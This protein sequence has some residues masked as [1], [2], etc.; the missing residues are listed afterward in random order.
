MLTSLQTE[1]VSAGAHQASR[2]E[3]L[4][5]LL[6]LFAAVHSCLAA[7]GRLVGPALNSQRSAAQLGW[8]V[9]DFDGDSRPDMAITRMEARDGG[10]VYWLELDLSTDRE[11]GS[12]RE[13]SNLPAA[14]SSIFGM[15]LTPR[16]VDGDRD[17]DI[18]V[19]M[20][21]TRRPVAVWINDGRGRFEE[22]DLSAYPALTALDGL[23]LSTP[24]WLDAAR[25]AYGQGPR[26]RLALPY[27]RGILQPLPPPRFR[28]AGRPELNV[29]RFVLERAPARAPPSRG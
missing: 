5:L 18:V 17:L 22:G 27:G 13:Q 1:G 21:I 9:A 7:P 16:D 10:Y 26:S 24:V 2:A 6:L 23:Q 28:A 15:H 14:V 3:K 12:S 8:A 20:G 19:T 11:N 29:S 4:P 25:I